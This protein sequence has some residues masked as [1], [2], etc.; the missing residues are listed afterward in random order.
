[1]SMLKQDAIKRERKKVKIDR[2]DDFPRP[3]RKG[4][5]LFIIAMLSISIISFLV[6][7][8]YKNAQSFLLAFQRYTGIDKDGNRMFEWSF[9]NFVDVYNDLFVKGD[10]ELLLSFKNTITLFFVENLYGIPMGCIVS[11]YLWKKI[12]GTTFFRTIFYLPAII[13]SVINVIMYQRIIAPNGLISSLIILTGGQPMP[14]LLTQDSTAF[15]MVI[16]YKLWMGFAGN[17]IILFAALCKIPSEIVESAQLDGVNAFQE[18]IH[19]CVPLSWPTIYVILLG[20]VAGVLAADGPILLLTGGNYSTTTIG[21]WN[22]KQVILSG[23][24]EYPSAV[25]MCMTVI[26]APLSLLA[27]SLLSRVYKDVEF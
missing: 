26:V 7:Y 19:I 22:Y 11:Y 1:M 16:A 5:V 25:G 6:F 4:K 20:F 12:P 9:Q 18:Y 24:Y 17:Y 10:S 15:L 14:G 27:K 13:T 23:S 21:Y 8:V 2:Y 3:L